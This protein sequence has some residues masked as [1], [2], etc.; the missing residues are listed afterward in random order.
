MDTKKLYSI[1][2]NFTSH[3]GRY[4]QLEGILHTDG[5]LTASS[6]FVLAHVN[7]EDYDFDN[8]GLSINKDGKIVKQKFPAFKHLMDLTGTDE[9]T[10]EYL[11]SI[12]F[13][14]KNI[15]TGTR[16]DHKFVI[17]TV[18]GFQ[19]HTFELSMAFELFESLGEIPSM[20]FGY[21][22]K[23]MVMHSKSCTVVIRPE[24]KPLKR[25]DLIFTVEEAVKINIPRLLFNAYKAPQ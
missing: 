12:R 18:E 3:D 7:H 11:E 17:L 4:P 19:L 25:N 14:L 21:A 10:E 6:G 22:L 23:P 20:S 2:Y 5:Y 16:E 13:A 8:E 15:P 24:T 1:L 9:I